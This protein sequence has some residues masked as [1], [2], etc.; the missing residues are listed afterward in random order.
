MDHDAFAMALAPSLASAVTQMSGPKKVDP[1]RPGTELFRSSPRPDLKPLPTTADVKESELFDLTEFD[2]QI[3]RENL[4][5]RFYSLELR[6]TEHARRVVDHIVNHL[7]RT[8]L[9]LL[10]GYVTYVLHPGEIQMLN[11]AQPH[12]L[13]WSLLGHAGGGNRNFVPQ[14]T[15]DVRP[16]VHYDGRNEKYIDAWYD[17][18]WQS[19]VAMYT[20]ADRAVF[21]Q[22]LR[23]TVDQAARRMFRML[24][25]HEAYQLPLVPIDTN[26]PAA[27]PCRS[28]QPH[29]FSPAGGGGQGHHPDLLRPRYLRQ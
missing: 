23:R 6:T 26:V 13:G 20:P 11:T 8:S 28:H 4:H 3:R 29:R 18:Y 19:Q 24:H 12:G 14:G 27:W 5:R 21:T 7:D 17:S 2:P 9:D 25:T 10:P 16:A 22:S 1:G 15:V